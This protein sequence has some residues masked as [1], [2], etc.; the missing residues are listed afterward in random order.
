MGQQREIN[1]L[2]AVIYDLPCLAGEGGEG[3]KDEKAETREEE[4]DI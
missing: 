4:V 2:A 1:P 3:K